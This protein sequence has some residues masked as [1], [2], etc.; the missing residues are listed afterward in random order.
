MIRKILA[1]LS[2]AASSI[3]NAGTYTLTLEDLDGAFN[4]AVEYGIP[5]S[6]LVGGR[7]QS[8]LDASNIKLSDGDLFLDF[9]LPDIDIESGCS[10]D[11]ELEDNHATVVIDSDS[12]MQFILDSLSKPVIASIDLFGRFNSDHELEIKA[13]FKVFGKCYRYI[14]RD[15]DIDLDG[16]AAINLV[17]T[18]HFN[19]KQ[20][21]G[22]R[23][24]LTPVASLQGEI[25]GL[26]INADIEMESGLDLLTILEIGVPKHLLDKVFKEI[27]KEGEKKL[28][29]TAKQL[30]DDALVNVEAD[31]NNVIADALKLKDGKRV[32][33]LPSDLPP[34]LS[35][36]IFD[37]LTN[38]QYAFF[39][40]TSDF[41]ENYKDQILY[42]LLI[43]D[44]I[45][46]Q[47][48]MARLMVMQ[49]DKIIPFMESMPTTTTP[50]AF[51]ETTIANYVAEY[52]ASPGPYYTLGNAASWQEPVSYTQE[53]VID[54]DA[55][56]SAVATR[57]GKYNT[58]YNQI[59]SIGM[60]VTSSFATQYCTDQHP[61]PKQSNYYKTITVEVSDGDGNGIK[62]SEWTLAPGT[63]FDLTPMPLA[64]HYQPYMQKVSFK[65]IPITA[66]TMMIEDTEAY[67]QAVTQYDESLSECTYAY[68]IAYGGKES[69]HIRTC[70]LSSNL[71][72]PKQSSYMKEVP[73][74]VGNGIC[75]L[76]MRVYKKDVDATNLKPLIAFHGGGWKWRGIE[77]IEAVVSQFTDAGY[78]VFA[79]FYRLLDEQAG[80]IECHNATWQDIVSDGESSLDWVNQY[81]HLYGAN[82][83]LPVLFGQSGGAHMSLW[84]AVNKPNDIHKIALMYGPTDAE[85][86]FK[87]A[88]LGNY[89]NAGGLRTMEQIFGIPDAL[90]SSLN[91]SRSDIQAH[92]FTKSIALSPTYYPPA[93][94]VQGMQDTLVTPS[95]AVRLCN[96]YSG[97][98]DSGPAIEYAGASR[99]I[100]NCGTS[101]KLHL[102]QNGGHG[103][104]FCP[105]RRTP[106]A[107]VCA[108]GVNG[109]D[110]AN[111]TDTYQKMVIWMSN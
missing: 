40:S 79:P 5:M 104:E 49:A 32:E 96:A 99:R 33:S 38:S 54:N 24:E 10:L 102:F 51:K 78:V 31:F 110:L 46:L 73:R 3:T 34:N 29:K 66:G 30:F 4:D 37:V 22:N 60:G 72:Y 44:N 14:D 55:Y 43:G 83:E 69:D 35:D 7:I 65:S 42:Y 26:D 17:A 18:I 36:R 25:R 85:D 58:C 108:A 41:L 82:Q 21:D 93:F 8:M 77:G 100:Y 106:E 101:G 74:P 57:N 47:D 88:R 90:D 61:M 20:L 75:E 91:L 1:A 53:T 86:I 80:N 98:V 71:K 63:S 50:S 64:G 16:S 45:A 52:G 67:A 6:Q 92:T 19:P 39:P 56:N 84:L 13:G 89:I 81:K 109:E 12:R 11:I 15:F 97:N 48:L 2:L 87:Q 28:E 111:F 23:I 59:I 27:S 107:N 68:T 105:S 94:I 70:E 103:M 95:Q 76:E 62:N 9:N